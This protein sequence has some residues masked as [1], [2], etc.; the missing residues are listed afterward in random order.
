MEIIS[1]AIFENVVN[2]VTDLDYKKEYLKKNPE[3]IN[4][5]IKTNYQNWAKIKFKTKINEEKII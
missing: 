1:N 5:Y 3:I 2:T 4:Y